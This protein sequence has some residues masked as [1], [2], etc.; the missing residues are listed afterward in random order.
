MGVRAIRVDK[1]EEPEIED[2]RLGFRV[3]HVQG[4]PVFV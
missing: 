2:E 3:E 1:H 4:R